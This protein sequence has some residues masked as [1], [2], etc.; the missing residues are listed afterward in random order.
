MNAT[1]TLD[2][3]EVKEIIANH[4]IDRGYDVQYVGLYVESA[5]YR[6]RFDKVTVEFLLEEE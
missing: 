3:K 5:S 2:L 4:Y 1:I 6:V